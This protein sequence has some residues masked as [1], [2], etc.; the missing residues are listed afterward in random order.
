MLGNENHALELASMM[1]SPNSEIM[2]PPNKV[3]RHFPLVD[4]T[5][6]IKLCD[7]GIGVDSRNLFIFGIVGQTRT[8]PQFVRIT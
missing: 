6:R 7:A 5:Y 1:S 3:Q 2:H 4:S 8:G